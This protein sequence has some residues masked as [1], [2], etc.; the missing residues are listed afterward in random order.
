MAGHLLENFVFMELTKQATFRRTRVQIFHLCPQA[1]G[2]VDFVLEDPAGRLVGIEVKAS[3]TLD[4]KDFRG[5]KELAS[6]VGKVFVRGIL[7]YSGEEVVPFGRDLH[8]MPL[9]ALWRLG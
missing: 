2:E 3:A 6:A 9:S 8:A 5:L 1:A 7:L 4:A